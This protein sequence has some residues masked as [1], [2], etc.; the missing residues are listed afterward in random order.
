MKL[1]KSLLVAP[2]TLG[3]LAPMS[4]TANEVTINDFNPAEELAVTNSRLDGLEARLNNFEA[5]SFSST[6]SASFGADFV[7]GAVDGAGTG[8]EAVSFDYQYG[9]TLSTSFTGE[10]SLDLVIETGNANSA[11]GTILDMNGMSDKMNL[12]GITYTFPLGDKTTVMVGDSTDVSA[13]YSTAC[14]YSAFTDLLGNCG[15]GTAA[16]LGGGTDASSASSAT[17]AAAYDFGNG[18][19]FAGGLSG[20]G[21]ATAGLFTKES[22]DVYGV[23]AA[24]NTDSY[25]V[26]LSYA[27]TDTSPTAESSFW[28]LNAFYSFDGEGLPSISV[29]FE[30]ED[31]SASE[32]KEGYFVG[33]SWDE[34]GPGSF[35]VGMSSTANFLDTDTE[36]YQ[37]EAAYS[38]PINDGMTITP[39][40]FI[41]EVDG[42]DDQTGVIVKTS[43][44]F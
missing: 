19:T 17:F 28:G 21:G 38:Y 42:A 18:F 16:G 24:Y 14:T 4:A 6:T 26:S 44:S 29:G 34:V 3:L 7:I 40:V 22:Y 33:L 10:D 8:K 12:D 13:L 35:S 39:G 27:L 5:G 9:M 36:T 20:A 23:Q 43:F 41:K 11:S 1:F 32:T 2:A 37:Y 15:S 25:G 31:P 30:S